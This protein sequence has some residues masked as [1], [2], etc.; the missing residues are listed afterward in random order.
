MARW[1]KLVIAGKQ[2]RAEDLTDYDQGFTE[3]DLSSDEPGYG[4]GEP[5]FQA[6]PGDSIQGDDGEWYC[7]CGNRADLE[8]FCPCNAEGVEV[9]P[10]PEAWNAEELYKCDRCGAIVSGKDGGGTLIKKGGQAI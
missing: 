7:P 6:G 9:E 2:A 1:W 10:T 3:G 5:G 8:G 4:P